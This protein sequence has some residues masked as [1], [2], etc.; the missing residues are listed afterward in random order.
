MLLDVYKQ[1]K[2]GK[3]YAPSVGLYV[4]LFLLEKESRRVR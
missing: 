4:G 2:P 1:V 3:M